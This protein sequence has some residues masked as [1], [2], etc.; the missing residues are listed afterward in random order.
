MNSKINTNIQDFLTW[1]PEEIFITDQNQN[2]HTRKEFLYLAM[3][4]IKILESKGFTRGDRLILSGNNSVE[5]LIKIFACFLAGIVVIPV[6]PHLPIEERVKL[7]KRFLAKELNSLSHSQLKP[8]VTL[9]AIPEIDYDDDAIILL[10]SGTTG[11]SKGIVH[12]LNSFF[13]SAI[14]FS[15]LVGIQ[16]WDVTLHNWPMTYMA[17]LFN[18]FAL[19]L[20]SHSSIVL[21]D[22]ISTSVLANYWRL[23][24]NLQPTIIYLSPTSINTLNRF[25]LIYG[26]D[27]S[28]GPL[29]SVKVIS[30]SSL[31]HPESARLFQNNFRL[32]ICPCYGITECGGSLTFFENSSIPYGVGKF[33][34]EID[35]KISNSGEIQIKTPYIGKRIILANGEEKVLSRDTY[36]LTGDIGYQQNGQLI[37]TGRISEIIKKGGYLINL[38]DIEKLLGTSASYSE[39]V[40]K[41]ILD[42]FWGEDYIIEFVGTKIISDSEVITEISRKLMALTASDS[43]PSKIVAV[44]SILRTNSGKVIRTLIRG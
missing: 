4:M 32:E 42:D 21:S 11:V 28:P 44:D 34:D 31:L 8:T 20:V 26:S 16:E 24:E 36:Y 23:L 39:L 7:Q 5:Y 29:K 41:P 27:F 18:L 14:S 10:S 25:R 2:T 30:T 15:R 12:S 19:P 43:F 33:S 13:G 1:N 22:S 9:D 35:S 38:N 6:D 37:I 40:A 3:K 17:G